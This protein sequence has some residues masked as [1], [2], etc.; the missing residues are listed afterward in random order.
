MGRSTYARIALALG[1]LAAAAP[2]AAEGLDAERF[3]PAIGTE[4]SFGFEHPAVPFHLGFGVGLFADLADDPVVERD[5]D[6]DI[7]SRPLDTASTLDFVATFGLFGWAELGVHLPFQMV[8]EGDDYP[9]AGGVLSASSGVGDLRLVPKAALV[10]S[11][12]ADNHVLLGIALPMSLPTGD[13]EALRGS[14][15]FAIGPRLLFALHRDRLGVGAGVGYQW[16]V[17]HPDGLPAGDQLDLGLMGSY[18]IL[19]PLRFQAEVAGAKQ[20]RADVDG[21][22]LSVEALAGL[23]VLP[24]EGL[25]LHVGGGLGLNDGIGAPDLRLIGGVRFSH[26]ASTRRGFADADGDGV[27][28]KDDDCETEAEDQDGFQDADGCPEPDND[29]D[30]ILDDKDEC[31][32]MPEEPGGDGDGCPSKTFVTF[33]DG[34]IQIFGKVRF[35][36][37]SSELDGKSAPLLDQIAAAMRANPQASKIRIEG[38]TDDLGDRGFNQKLSEERADAVRRALIDRGVDGDRLETR[39]HG[40][41]QPTAPNASAAGRAKNRRVEFLIVESK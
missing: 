5:A 30:G 6:D 21:A 10:R 25:S 35:K 12:S 29:R 27:L 3:A 41:M 33:L 26:G 14:D 15:G 7:L 36:L 8:Y 38:H 31:P 24:T 11:G 34:E 28:D 9:Y 32:D 2:A 40:E 4:P 39:G 18:Q 16:R 22:D 13:G 20:L 17:D 23:I 1:M 37:G 19:E